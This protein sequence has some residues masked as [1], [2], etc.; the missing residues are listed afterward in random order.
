MSNREA[1]AKKMLERL[2]QLQPGTAAMNA[3]GAATTAKPVPPSA[4]KKPLASDI[5]RRMRAVLAQLQN[6]A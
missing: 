2:D 3:P 6:Q 4:T 1:F 5:E